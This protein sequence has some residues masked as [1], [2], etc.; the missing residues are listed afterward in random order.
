MSEEKF[1][2][3]M[4]R[5]WC[6]LTKLRC[7]AAYW[8]GK[9]W[10]PPVSSPQTI[11]HFLHF[12]SIY[13]L[14]FFERNPLL[15]ESSN[16]TSW[17]N[18]IPLWDRCRR[19]SIHICELHGSPRLRPNNLVAFWTVGLSLSFLRLLDNLSHLSI[20]KGLTDSK[21]DCSFLKSI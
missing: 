16:Y 4:S 3:S 5:H 17:K 12:T 15:K 19:M 18:L 14:I 11:Y 7:Q 1:H 9:S 13:F 8:N 2:L 10:N 6:T 20:F 21:L